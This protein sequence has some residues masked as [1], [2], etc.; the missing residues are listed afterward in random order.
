MSIEELKAKR[1]EILRLAAQRGVRNVRL[2][3]SVDIYESVERIEKYA[4]RA[5]S[6][7]F[8][9]RY[10]KVRWTDIIGMRK[11]LVHNYFGI[12]VEAV[13]SV[14]ERDLP[15]LKAQVAAMLGKNST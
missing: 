3:G 1:E 2:F 10:P 15:H 5:L 7:E 8:R 9:D 13:W 12:D 14:V 4:A 6:A 11:V